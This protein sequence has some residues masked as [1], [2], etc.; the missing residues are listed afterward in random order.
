MLR[1]RSKLSSKGQVTIPSKV[2]SALGVTPDDQILFVVDD[3]GRVGLEPVHEY[4]LEELDGIVPA[5]DRPTS[6]D[7]RVEI[8]EAMEEM[9]DK[10]VREMGGR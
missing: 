7:F 6:P 3:N 2:R 4:S 1:I 5:L 9:A 8:G 10:I